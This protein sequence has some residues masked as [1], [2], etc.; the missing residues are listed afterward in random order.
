MDRPRIFKIYPDNSPPGLAFIRRRVRPCTSLLYSGTDNQLR[1]G[2]LFNAVK[3]Q[4]GL[5]SYLLSLAL[6]SPPPPA[7]PVPALMPRLPPPPSEDDTKPERANKIAGLVINALRL[8]E[9]D[10]QQTAKFTRE[11]VVQSLVPWMEKCVND[12]NEA[13]SLFHIYLRYYFSRSL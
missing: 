4:Y 1:A 8:G 10:I 3:K 13:V 7:V 5:H 2:A 11:F 12:W 9:Q 6:P